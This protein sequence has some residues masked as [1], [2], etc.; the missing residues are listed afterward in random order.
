[1]TNANRNAYVSDYIRYLTDVSVRRQYEC[2]ARGFRAC[3][4]PKALTLLTPQ[5]LQSLVE[6]VQDIDIGELKRYT[7]YVGWDAS[8]R[9]V[10]DFWS[11]VR[12]FDDTMKRKLLEFVTASDRVPVGGVKNIM[13]ILQKNGSEDEPNGRLPTSYTC[14]GTLLLPE[15]K[16][17]EM[18]KERLAMALENAQGFGFA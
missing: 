18:L 16:D 1:V 10:K 13:F 2:F 8:H 9:T 15:Y 12:R 11:I 3:L 4:H 14:Y 5:I 7:R 6:G 17:K